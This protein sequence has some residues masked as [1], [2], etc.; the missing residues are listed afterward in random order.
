MT[1]HYRR[2][3]KDPM[4]MVEAF[5][6]AHRIAFYPM[7]FQAI[8]SMMKFGI[9]SDICKS[10]GISRDEIVR[11]SGLSTYAVDLM[12][13]VALLEKIV[14]NQDGKYFPTKLALL[15]NE[16]KAVKVNMDFMHDVCY[17]G[18]FALDESFETG[19]PEGLKVF[20][21]W[22]TIYQGLHHLPDKAKEVW[23]NF[24]N[25]YSD[26]VFDI[27]VKEVIKNNPKL[28]Y[29]IGGNTAKFEVALFSANSD[30]RCRII[31]LP[32]MI[33]KA[34]DNLSTVG[35]VDRAEF[36]PMD[37]LDPETEVPKGADA[38]WMS[39]FLDC[40][41]PEKIVFILEKA[42]RA[43]NTNGRIFVLEP[44]IDSS[45]DIA[46]LALTN[47]SLYFTCMANGYSRMYRQTEMEEFINKA[48]LRVLHAHEEIGEFSYTLLECTI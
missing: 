20:G 35:L 12:L 14:R 47:I 27:A 30:V 18:A 8:R 32:L 3:R 15:L 46:A 38:I 19:K 48:G 17:Q 43:L 5:R 2:V 11:I 36:F 33:E 40:F 41:S 39:Q 25:Y 4:T 44:F 6:E 1:E 26:L 23:F 45:N 13:E 28:V 21:D 34:K 29:D 31:D 10:S 7:M 37:I 42:K 22:E 24:D 16:D 9:L